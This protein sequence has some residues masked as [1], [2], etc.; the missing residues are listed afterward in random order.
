MQYVDLFETLEWE[1]PPPIVKQVLRHVRDGRMPICR[2]LLTRVMGGSVLT[3]EALEFAPPV[4][5]PALY[6]HFLVTRVRFRQFSM[7][8]LVA[9]ARAE[10]ARAAPVSPAGDAL[11]LDLPIWAVVELRGRMGE[12]HELPAEW[13]EQIAAEVRGRPDVAEE[14]LDVVEAPAG[15]RPRVLADPQPGPDIVVPSSTHRPLEGSP[16]RTRPGVPELGRDPAMTTPSPSETHRLLTDAERVVGAVHLPRG[17]TA[18]VDRDGP[19][20]TLQLLGDQAANRIRAAYMLD[21]TL[22]AHGLHLRLD[23][24]KPPCEVLGEWDAETIVMIERLAS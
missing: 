4:E 21:D 23:G 2:D 10:A 20:I 9:D 14:D 16:V 15:M 17:Y 18:I 11:P 5:E 7:A 8:A 13:L 12:V 6:L 24:A 22:R 3:G 1:E 19:E